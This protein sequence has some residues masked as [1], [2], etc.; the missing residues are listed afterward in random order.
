MN[1]SWMESELN[2]YFKQSRSKISKMQGIKRFI[3]RLLDPGISIEQDRLTYLVRKF[4]IRNYY[5]IVAGIIGI[6]TIKFILNP[7][8]Y[9]R[10][11]A[12][13]W[14][15]WFNVIALLYKKKTY[16]LNGFFSVLHFFSSFLFS[17]FSTQK[18]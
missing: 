15:I 8:T 2:C 5:I 10:S 9:W 13:T 11:Y 4:E 6:T 12:V 14:I 18:I 17:P 1:H 7:T 3:S 16:I